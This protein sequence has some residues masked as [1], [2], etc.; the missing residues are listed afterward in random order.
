MSNKTGSISLARVLE[1]TCAGL[2]GLLLL[3]AAFE[4]FTWMLW[5]KSYAAIEEIQGVLAVWLG[6]L[7][8]A[9]C[10][11]EGLHLAVDLVVRGLPTRWQGGVA[12]IPGFASATFGA[13]LALYGVRLVQ[14][15]QNTLPGTGWSASLHYQPAVVAGLLIG[16]FGLKDAI[17]GAI[18]ER[19]PGE[20]NHQP[21]PTP[22][23]DRS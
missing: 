2:L 10:L 17:H 23:V 7:A 21:T 6:L 1:A 9:Y 12:R 5:H 4:L 20:E 22:P 19:S 15:V 16:W 8:A 13:L 3:N 18:Q 14:A 11:A